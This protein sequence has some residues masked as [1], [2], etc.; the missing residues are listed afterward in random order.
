MC[1]TMDRRP[2]KLNP[3][4]CNDCEQ[5]AETYHGGAQVEMTILFAD[6]RGSTRMAEVL[7]TSDFSR[8]IN[9]F[10]QVNTRLLVEADAMIEKLIGDEVTGI[11]LPGFS[12][13]QHA[14]AAI[15][16]AQKLLTATGHGD[17]LGRWV[18]V[19]IGI[20]TG[21]AFMGAVGQAGGVTDIVVLGEA[22]NTAAR[23]TS[24]AAPGEILISE[25]T[26]VNAN[27]TV[28]ELQPK[29]L[30]LKD[31]STAVPVWSLSMLPR[32][33]QE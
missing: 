30:H 19:G 5:F 10:Y 17:T 8:L 2:S 7:G 20:H 9:H 18:P 13:Q 29:E 6:A 1:L 21:T 15:R 4:L 33:E 11:F 23:I 14:R 16:A 31:V 25:T 22:V 32:T 26:R 3:Q 28:P 27:F 12:G 24:Q